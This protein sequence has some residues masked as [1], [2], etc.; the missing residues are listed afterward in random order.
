MEQE[1][2]K[3]K[4]LYAVCLERH[5]KLS[6]SKPSGYAHAAKD[7]LAVVGSQE[8][9]KL[10]PH[11]SLGFISVENTFASVILLGL[12]VGRNLLVT[13]DGRWIGG[14]VP[15]CYQL[16][17][18]QIARSDQSDE[19]MVCIDEASGLVSGK[20][21]GESFYTEDKQ[22]TPALSDLIEKLTAYERDKEHNKG[23]CAVLQ[24]YNLFEAWP[25]SIQNP[26][27]EHSQDIT[28]LY[29]INEA[30]LNDLPGDALVELRST[31]ALAVAF[32]QLFSMQN[33]HRLAEL[34]LRHDAHKQHLAR[35][36]ASAASLSQGDTISFDNLR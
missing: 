36:A 20:G 19:L 15:M 31:G 23:A 1:K 34:S 12:E 8:M 29:R 35:Q 27:G 18:F 28:G 11:A 22:P 10:V 17:P 26:D 16:Y 5:E 7:A 25:L 30:T 6:W 2:E 21:T 14:A 3:A 13:M 33:V 24:K 32:A 4:E 9:V